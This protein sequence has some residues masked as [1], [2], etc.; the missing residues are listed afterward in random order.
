MIKPQLPSVAGALQAGGDILQL[1]LRH[2]V[3]HDILGLSIA[4]GG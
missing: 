1:S 4:T 2:K 3:R